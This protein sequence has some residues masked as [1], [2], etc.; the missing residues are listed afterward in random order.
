[1]FG[2][3]SKIAE[4]I[5]GEV[6]CGKPLES[7]D[8]DCLVV[9]KQLN[10]ASD[11]FS[12]GSLCQAFGRLL[13]RLQQKWNE[14]QARIRLRGEEPNLIHFEA[15]LPNHVLAKR[16]FRNMPMLRRRNHVRDL[17]KSV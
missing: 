9:M 16:N 1:M 6:T 3:R 13:T 2:Q 4:A 8:Y 7:D 14:Q 5:L 11:L 15:W 12:L 17:M 10:Y